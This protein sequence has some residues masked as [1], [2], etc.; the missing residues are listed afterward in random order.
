MRQKLVG[1]LGV[2]KYGKSVS[3]SIGFEEKIR[4]C[5]SHSW[6]PTADF[7]QYLLDGIASLRNAM[8]HPWSTYPPP[9]V[10]PRNKALW[11][12]L[13]NH[14]F[15]V[16][17][18]YWTLGSSGSSFIHVRWSGDFVY[19]PGFLS[20]IRINL[21]TLDSLVFSWGTPP[22]PW[23]ATQGAPRTAFLWSPRYVESRLTPGTAHW[24]SGLCRGKAKYFFSWD[25]KHGQ[26][27]VVNAGKRNP[28][29]THQLR[30]V[31]EIPLFIRFILYLMFG[32][33]ISKEIHVRSILPMSQMGSLF[34]GP[35]VLKI[36]GL[37]WG[38]DVFFLLHGGLQPSDAIHTQF[39]T[40][41]QPTCY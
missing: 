21:L 39:M 16:M 25:M 40:Q 27:H 37:C 41:L 14:W 11:S 30:L 18:P 6:K 12:G 24:H 31:V 35:G 4:W 34:L 23:L 32:R 28:G 5:W 20:K 26:V 10:P 19:S 15:P 22:N 7:P 36:D 8:S 2:G 3:I 13:L 9:N 17:R 1:A 38:Q 29:S 33:T